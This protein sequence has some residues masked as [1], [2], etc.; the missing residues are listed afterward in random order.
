MNPE[1]QKEIVRKVVDN[2]FD[3]YAIQYV[4]YQFMVIEKEHIVETGTNILCTKWNVGYPGGHFA[5]AMVDNNLSE[6]F[7]R[8]DNINEHCIKFYLMLMYNVG[9][10]TS[11]F[12]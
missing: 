2:Y 12:Q 7:G 8:A 3:S 11:L 4:P 9:A 1:N 6:A 5:Q 10:P